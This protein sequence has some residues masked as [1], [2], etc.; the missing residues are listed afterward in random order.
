MARSEEAV[1]VET[2][3][4]VCL[5]SKDDAAR[6][7]EGRK[8][9][10]A[11]VEEREAAYVAARK[12]YR[13]Q[14]TAERRAAL[15]AAIGHR[16]AACNSHERAGILLPMLWVVPREIFWPVF[17]DI[18]PMCDATSGGWNGHAVVLMREHRPATE[19]M[20][21]EIREATDAL[22]DLIEV[23][24]GADRRGVRR[25]SWTTDQVK[26]EFFAVHRRGA[27]FPDPVIAHA[28][29]PK[30]HVFYADDGRNEAEVLLDPRRL[31]KL[32]VKSVA[33][34]VRNQKIEAT[35][36]GY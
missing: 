16:A 31:R 33:H 35:K 29:I 30:V 36:G 24:R 25:F 6:Y 15:I 11:A 1:R 19:F 23:W 17:M 8:A 7:A 22:P 21:P 28:F 34:I 3:W 4:G 14:P 18:W 27:P 20:T 26:A 2:D 13:N 32:T 9:F 12:L 5:M 10:A